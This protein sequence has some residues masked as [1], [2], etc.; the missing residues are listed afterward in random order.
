MVSEYKNLIE[1]R[2]SD[3]KAYDAA[4]KNNLLDEICEMF[5]WVKNTKLKNGYWTKEKCI[6]EALKYD[7]KKNWSRGSSS[8]YASALKNKWM[9]EC[10]SHME[11]L[12]QRPNNYWTLELCKEEALKYK[13]KPEWVKNSS[14]SQQAARKNGWYAECTAHMV[15]LQKPFGF[16]VF[17]R[18]K[19][20]ALKYNSKSD[21]AKNSSSSYDAAKKNGW[22]DECTKHMVELQ[23]PSGFWTLERCKEEALKYN[24]RNEWR[25]KGKNSYQAAMSA[26]FLDKCTSHMSYT[27]LKPGH[28]NKENCLEEAKK[29]NKKFEWQKKSSSCYNSARKNGWLDECCAHMVNNNK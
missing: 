28:W 6:D 9:E 11:K 18:C 21:W 25:E 27:R 8:S 15:E 5:G 24:T 12:V 2:K 17:E 26:K 13:T 10:T 20:E 23:K 16:W 22:F 19:E 1:W 29:Y 14:A 4:R 7:T 3:S